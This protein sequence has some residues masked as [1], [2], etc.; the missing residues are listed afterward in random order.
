MV[1]SL[2]KE[3]IF[4]P[5]P[6]HVMCLSDEFMD[7]LKHIRGVLTSPMCSVF[8]GAAPLHCRE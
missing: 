2:E 5:H 7:T 1:K 6:P 3:K 8:K 4:V